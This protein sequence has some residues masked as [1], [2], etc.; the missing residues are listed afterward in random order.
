MKNI[1]HY[2]EAITHLST[3]EDIHE[4][5]KN[6]VTEN[7]F[8]Y[9]WYMQASSQIQAKNRFFNLTNYPNEFIEEYIKRERMKQDPVVINSFK[10]LEPQ[11]WSEMFDYNKL[12]KNE[13]YENLEWAAKFNISFGISC[14]LFMLGKP[15]GLLHFALA[16]DFAK[17]LID[18][19]QFKFRLNTL[20]FFIFQKINM[21]HT[22][23]PEIALAARETECLLWAAKGKNAWEIAKIL[24]LSE[25]TVREYLTNA[26]SKL[27][28]SSITEA[29]VKALLQQQ[30]TPFNFVIK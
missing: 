23:Q 7:G 4:L 14:P 13:Y 24:H 3:L 15:C 8:L 16:K 12:N 21:L 29:V 6:F 20:T 25:H 11:F 18:I 2:Y 10:S 17:H 28:A 9:Y 5:L 22:E 27:Q 30:I 19:Q 1:Q 26:K